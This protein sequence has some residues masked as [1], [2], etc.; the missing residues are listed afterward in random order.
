MINKPFDLINKT[1]VL[2]LISN[3]VREGRMLDYKETLPGGSDSDKT[4][5]LAD[6][7]SFA[8]AA[9]GHIL[10][11]IREKRD[12]GK[13]TGIPESAEGLE[14]VNVDSEIL[15]L[16]SII[17]TVPWCQTF[18]YLF[19]RI[20]RASRFSVQSPHKYSFPRKEYSSSLRTMTLLHPEHFVGS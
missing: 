1:E 10:Y 20:L 9:G 3:E 13:P 18:I 4:E 15:R 6:V 14:G 12:N 17:R 7:S 11:G 5:F 8:N 19:R 2:N 16:E